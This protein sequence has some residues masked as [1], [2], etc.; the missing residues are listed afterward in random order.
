[1]AKKLSWRTCPACMSRATKIFHLG[2]GKLEC[3]ICD[4]QYE[5]PNG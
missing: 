1:M 3:Q 5:A 4:H 2:T